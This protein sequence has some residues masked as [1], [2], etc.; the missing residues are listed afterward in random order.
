M[1]RLPPHP[2]RRVFGGEPVENVPGC[3]RP[4]QNQV[5][6]RRQVRV[7][8]GPAAAEDV[9]LSVGTAA[10]YFDS[11]VPLSISLMAQVRPETPAPTTTASLKPD[12]GDDQKLA[13]GVMG[14]PVGDRPHD[15]SLDQPGAAPPDD[16]QVGAVL[17]AEGDDRSSRVAKLGG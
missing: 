9:V 3:L 17:L 15:E 6:G 4:S 12:S 10:T 1:K 14:E 16:Q 8:H 5:L 11:E 7:P 13:G 2:A